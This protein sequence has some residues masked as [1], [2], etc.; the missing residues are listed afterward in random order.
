MLGLSFL[1]I[2]NNQRINFPVV[3]TCEQSAQ[4]DKFSQV[5][6]LIQ[7]L[8]ADGQPFRPEWLYNKEMPE[9]LKLYLRNIFEQRVSGLSSSVDYSSL[10][11]E[12]LFDLSPF[13]GETVEQFRS[14][15]QPILDRYENTSAEPNPE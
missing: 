6:Q 10:S 4:Q 7:S 14:R 12:E 11:D 15:V 5:M 8:S 9:E 1:Q 2:A 3:D 13:H